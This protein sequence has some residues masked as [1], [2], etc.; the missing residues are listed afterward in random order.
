M[1]V[2]VRTMDGYSVK[3][4]LEWRSCR[5]CGMES[6]KKNFFRPFYAELIWAIFSGCNHVRN[7]RCSR[8]VSC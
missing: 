3:T 2:K 5:P 6:G 8:E 4:V 7:P 1:V